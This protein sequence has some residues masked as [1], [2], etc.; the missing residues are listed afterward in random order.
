MLISLLF[1]HLVTVSQIESLFTENR[2]TT[3]VD[4]F[5]TASSSDQWPKTPKTQDCFHWQINYSFQGNAKKQKEENC[6]NLNKVWALLLMELNSVE[7]GQRLAAGIPTLD[8]YLTVFH[9][10]P[11]AQCW[12]RQQKIFCTSTKEHRDNGGGEIPNNILPCILPGT[13]YHSALMA[14]A[15]LCPEEHM[16]KGRWEP[17]L[18]AWEGTSS[19]FSLC[20]GV[21]GWVSARTLSE[22][23]GLGALRHGTCW[24]MSQK[25]ISGSHSP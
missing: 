2:Y 21:T 25:T 12:V 9:Q 15:P 11:L 1:T 17:Q 5:L 3:C 8:R 16:G 6:K 24:G 22:L 4:S 13:Q 7:S 14:P 23:S 18:Q 19:P 10:A 20:P